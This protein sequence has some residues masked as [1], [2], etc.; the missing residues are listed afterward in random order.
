MDGLE[1]C[2][3]TQENVTWPKTRAEVSVNQ[4]MVYY[5]QERVPVTVENASVL[6]RN[7][8]FQENSV[9]VMTRIVTNMMAL[10]VQEM[11]YVA[12]ETASAGQVGLEMLV[13]SGLGVNIPNIAMKH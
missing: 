12:V 10:F 13:R 6:P 7:G 3:S 1:N 11:A 9:N 4:P 5:A 2:V 8:T